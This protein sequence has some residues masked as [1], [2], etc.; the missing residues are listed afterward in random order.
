MYFLRGGGAG[1]HGNAATTKHFLFLLSPLCVEQ[2]LFE[3][4]AA[5]Q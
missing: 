1:E 3:E 2:W 4:G 5:A